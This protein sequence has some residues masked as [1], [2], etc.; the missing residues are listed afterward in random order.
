M[1]QQN[2]RITDAIRT[3]EKTSNSSLRNVCPCRHCSGSKTCGQRQPILEG[4]R[5]ETN[6]PLSMAAAAAASRLLETSDFHPPPKSVPCQPGRQ[7]HAIFTSRHLPQTRDEV[8]Q[9]WKRCS[10]AIA[11]CMRHARSHTATA[12]TSSKHDNSVRI[13]DDA[14]HGRCLSSDE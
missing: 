4:Q 14:F 7:G 12:S 1:H 11:C 6:M 9:N 8:I 13:A 5:S 3:L 10:L 2:H